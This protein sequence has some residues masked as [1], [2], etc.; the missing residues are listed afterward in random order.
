MNFR[1]LQRLEKAKQQDVL[2]AIEL[3]EL[4][5]QRVQECKDVA[6]QQVGCGETVRWRISNSERFSTMAVGLI[7]VR[8]KYLEFYS[9]KTSRSFVSV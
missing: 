6:A 7:I 4:K 2:D 9:I 3:K 1:S 5:S 8:I